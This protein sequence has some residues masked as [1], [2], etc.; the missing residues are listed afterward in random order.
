MFQ[1]VLQQQTTV[2]G[3]EDVDGLRAET[4][5]S[6]FHYCIDYSLDA[7]IQEVLSRSPG[8]THQTQR[9]NHSHQNS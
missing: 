2:Y 4:T 8:M 3:K 7:H 1:S 5:S 6:T 9:D